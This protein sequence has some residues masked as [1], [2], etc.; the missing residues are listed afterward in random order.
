MRHAAAIAAFFAA[1]PLLLAATGSKN[2]RTKDVTGSYTAK[3]SGGNDEFT[4]E[5]VQGEN[6]VAVEFLGAFG[7]SAHT[8]DCLMSGTSSGDGKWKL[9]GTSSKGSVAVMGEKIVFE[10]EQPAECCGVGFQGAPDFKFADRK[11]PQSCTVKPAKSMF[12]NPDEQKTPT[13]KYVVKG[14]K[15][16]AFSEGDED[17]D[18]LILARFA[19]KKHTAGFLK[20]AELTCP[21]A[22]KPATTPTEEPAATP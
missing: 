12:Q 9:Q 15:V 16:E 3:G 11:A 10:L 21:P 13:K 1:V 7:I 19:G 14:D 5:I 4:L 8:C 18:D 22:A 17:A 6:D 20:A 2:I